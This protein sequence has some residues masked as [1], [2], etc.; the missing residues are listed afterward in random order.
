ML[1]IK[2]TLKT[3]APN[4]YAADVAAK[5]PGKTFDVFLAVDGNQLPQDFLA[6]L[7]S[8]GF[9]K[10]ATAS[11]IHNDGKK[12]T[13]LHYSKPGTGIFQCW[14]DE[15]RESTLQ[16]LAQIFSNV[17]MTMQPRVMGLAEAFK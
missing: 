13:D 16:A 5:P 4:I 11:Y 17:G 15:E 9:A 8:L 14:T 2:S 7:E 12:V 6:S 3:V 1:F 10:A